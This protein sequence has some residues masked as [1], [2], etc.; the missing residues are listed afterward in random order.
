LSVLRCVRENEYFLCSDQRALKIRNGVVEIQLPKESLIVFT[1]GVKDSIICSGL[2]FQVHVWGLE[3]HTAWSFNP[4]TNNCVVL[5]N[6]FLDK[7]HDY[8]YAVSNTPNACNKLNVPYSACERELVEIASKYRIP[9]FIL[10]VRETPGSLP[11][12]VVTHGSP[13][14]CY[15]HLMELKASSR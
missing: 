13:D 3:K 7:C 12:N 2:D 8:V 14:E 4:G 15:L 9:V 6:V 1:S 10:D 5:T 11:V